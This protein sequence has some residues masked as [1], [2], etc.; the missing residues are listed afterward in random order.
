[1]NPE[2]QRFRID[3]AYDGRPYEGWQSQPGGNTVQD[4]LQLALHRI[5]PEAGRLQGS[6]RTDSGVS[7]ENQ[8]AHFDVPAEWRMQGDD[9][10][11][12]LNANLPAAIRV[13]GCQ[14]VTSD[15]HARFSAVGKTYRY[16]FHT[17]PVLPPLQ[18]GLS[19]HLPWV[20]EE[21]ITE[22]TNVLQEITGTHDFRSFSAN[23][24]D[25]KD[26]DRN[27][28]RTIF[29][30]DLLKEK[31][32]QYVIEV[33]GNGFLYKMVRFLVGTCTSHLRKKIT[34]EEIKELLEGKY[35]EQ[36]AP[37]C[38]PPDGLS[39]WQVHYD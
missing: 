36:K 5:C 31:E 16:R 14:A 17:A 23:R 39:L 11:K 22:M 6:G 18:A 10:R 34:L 7:A 13:Y 4:V 12:A 15:F 3:L 9:W 27:T 21:Q 26:A 8:V 29:S 38:A 25:G 19:W 32:N 2:L 30:T 33:H 37:H 20:S 1:M 24:N 28:T 35:P